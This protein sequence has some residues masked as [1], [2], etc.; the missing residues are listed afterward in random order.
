MGTLWGLQISQYNKSNE[1]WVD[2]ELNGN[3]SL[4]CFTMG[5]IGQSLA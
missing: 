1:A 3:R 5:Q 2:I 4:I